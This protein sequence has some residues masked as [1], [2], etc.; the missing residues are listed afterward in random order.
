MKRVIL[1]NCVDRRFAAHLAV[2]HIVHARDVGWARL[3]NGNLLAAAESAG[4]DVLVTVDKQMRFQQNIQARKICLVTIVTR[5]VTY[6]DIF[7]LASKVEDAIANAVP[8]TSIEV[9]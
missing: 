2:D 8:G 7:P 6:Q 9:G 5:F 1:D 4:Y 3:T